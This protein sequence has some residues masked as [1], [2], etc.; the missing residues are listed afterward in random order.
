MTK[1]EMYTAIR[2]QVADN[3]EMVAF[4]D[5]EIELLNRKTVARKPTKTQIENEEFKKVILNSLTEKMTVADINKA[6]LPTLSGQKIT[7][8][9]TALKKDGKVARTEEKG[10]AY[11]ELA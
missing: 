10:V 9:M 11:F 6:Y 4:I 8:L 2:E 7:A 3:A 5:H 1:R